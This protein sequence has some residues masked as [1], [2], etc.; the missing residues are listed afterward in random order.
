VGSSLEP[1]PVDYPDMPTH[2][3]QRVAWTTPDAGRAH[4]LAGGALRRRAV[5]DLEADIPLAQ[6]L[7]PSVFAI[8]ELWNQPR[9]SSSER[10]PT[11]TVQCARNRIY[12]GWLHG[13]RSDRPG[14]PRTPADAQYARPELWRTT[15]YGPD[16][17]GGSASRASGSSS[18]C[19]SD[20]CRP[21]VRFPSRPSQ[22]RCL[23]AFQKSASRR[24]S[25][26]ALLKS[27]LIRRIA[28]V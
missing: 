15:A 2:T 21:F 23:R 12:W 22:R 11:V 27:M 17:A 9:I 26:D 5:A 13:K 18:P 3:K 28:S 6:E 14:V 16:P 1:G 10:A 8:A 25:P 24:S 20:E 19:E 7:C 4:A